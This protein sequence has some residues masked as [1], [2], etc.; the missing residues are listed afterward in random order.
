MGIGNIG[1]TAY[2]HPVKIFIQAYNFKTDIHFSYD[3]RIP[4][5]GRYG[6]FKYFKQVVFN[7]RKLQ[8][9]LEY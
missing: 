3:H 1:I 9:E 4:L 2:V 7:E 8:V 6:F 5:L